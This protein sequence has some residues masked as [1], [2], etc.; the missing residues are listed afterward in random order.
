MVLRFSKFFLAPWRVGHWATEL[1]WTKLIQF[2]YIFESREDSLPNI[3]KK[4]LN[5]SV[6]CSGMFTGRQVCDEG[7]YV[8]S[9]APDTRP[10]LWYT[11]SFRDSDKKKRGSNIISF[12]KNE[13][14]LFQRKG[15]RVMNNSVIPAPHLL[16]SPKPYVPTP[17]LR[18]F[19]VI[20]EVCWDY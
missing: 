7:I 18:C 17:I 14:R 13:I 20:L 2:E 19:T 8:L 3:R 5:E 15:S 4:K 12:H 10:G 11:H 6:V 9:L 16:G 1:N